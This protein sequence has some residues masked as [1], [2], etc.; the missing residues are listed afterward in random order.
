[1]HNHNYNENQK[2]VFGTDKPMACSACGTTGVKPRLM[3]TEDDM[4]IY[5]EGKYICPRCGNYFH[6]GA[7]S[8]TPKNPEESA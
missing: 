5:E 4:F 8:K 6:R 7:I 1:M 3:V 2:Q